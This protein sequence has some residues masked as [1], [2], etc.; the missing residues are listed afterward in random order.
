[1]AGFPSVLGLSNVPVCVCVCVC[2][3]VL[4][5]HLS[6]DRYLSCFRILTTVNNAAMNTDMQ[7]F[8]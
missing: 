6:A 5:T 1:M 2:V 3:C 7:I 8:P 4:F